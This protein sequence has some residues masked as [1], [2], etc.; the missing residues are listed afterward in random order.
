MAHPNTEAAPEHG[1]DTPTIETETKSSDQP[2]PNRHASKAITVEEAAAELSAIFDDTPEERDIKR[3]DFAEQAKLAADL[4]TVKL[5]D[6]GDLDHTD[7]YIEPDYDNDYG[8][9]YLDDF[10]DDGEE[11][12]TSANT[13]E[14]LQEKDLND[15]DEHGETA[16][17]AAI[18]APVS[19]SKEQKDIF[20]ALPPEAKQVIVERERER[21]KGFQVKATEI[22]AE[23]KQMQALEQ[24]M[25]EERQMYANELSQRIAANMVA[26]DEGLLDPN[27]PTYNPAEFYAQKEN[28]DLLAAQHNEM[29]QRANA[30]EAL[31]QHNNQFAMMEHMQENEHVLNQSVP[32]WSDMAERHQV[33]D[34]GGRYG[35]APDE[36]Q[37]ASPAEVMLLS[38]AMRFDELMAQKPD[39]Q[40]QVKRAPKVQKPGSKSK[41]SA[42]K[43]LLANAQKKLKRSGSVDD[44]AAV[45][46][47]IMKD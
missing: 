21:D 15:N 35:F 24:Q 10:G 38:K 46:S 9:E 4:K 32:G 47:H 18:P 8:D 5:N 33:I 6:R 44:A 13:P 16:E 40:N 29:Q 30:Y 41:Y 11:N 42:N 2:P 19:W 45:L 27:S 17:Q 37:S 22:A 31:Y 23:R 3:R 26:P 36:I 14:E 1:V 43:R 20:D 34:Y 28:Y 7:H 25:I 12:D 39:V